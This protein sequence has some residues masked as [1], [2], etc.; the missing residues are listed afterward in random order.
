MEFLEQQ[1]N[2]SKKIAFNGIREKR[3]IEN[4]SEN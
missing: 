1:K 4:M 3:Y 2:S